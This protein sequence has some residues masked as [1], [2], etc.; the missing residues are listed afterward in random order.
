MRQRGELIAHPLGAAVQ[1]G[2]G[3]A[4]ITA[5]VED[6]QPYGRRR[7]QCAS[8]VHELR[9]AVVRVQTVVVDADRP[10][11]GLT[12]DEGG[13]AHQTLVARGGHHPQPVAEF[14][15]HP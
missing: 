3:G 8:Q 11:V 10:A 13:V 6:T 1:A 5:E 9:G 12:A 15:C 14:D 2:A 7:G 4:A